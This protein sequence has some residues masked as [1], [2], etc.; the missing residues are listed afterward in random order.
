MEGF[1]TPPCHGFC[2]GDDENLVKMMLRMIL[3]PSVKMLLMSPGRSTGC[4]QATSQQ[5]S[6]NKPI[7]QQQLCMSHQQNVNQAWSAM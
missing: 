6:I 1:G 5:P 7:V 4:D 2:S 3:L